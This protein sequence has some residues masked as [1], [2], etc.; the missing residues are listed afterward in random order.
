MSDELTLNTDLKKTKLSRHKQYKL[1]RLKRDDTNY[2][3]EYR[4]E[5]KKASI[6]VKQIQYK[7]SK[8]TE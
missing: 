5:R 4:L 8:S 3:T 1:M 2:S 6:S 7:I